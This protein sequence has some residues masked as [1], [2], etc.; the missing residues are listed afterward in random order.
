MTAIRAFSLF[1]AADS[2]LLLLNSLFLHF[3]PHSTMVYRDMPL[4]IPLL[5][6]GYLLAIYGLLILAQRSGVWRRPE[7]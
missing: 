1:A 6:T 3:T 5:A 7:G 2:T 4:M